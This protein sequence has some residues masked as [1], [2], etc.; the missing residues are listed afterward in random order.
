MSVP[1][2]N[3]NYSVATG[4]NSNDIN[5]IYFSTVDPTAYN[6][7]FPIQKKWYNTVNRSLWMLE[8]FDSTSGFPLANWVNLGTSLENV[9]QYAVLVGGAN[10]TIDS[11][12]P[13]ASTTKVLVS[14]G[15][16]ANPSWQN[17]GSG[18]L[19]LGAFGSSPNSSGASLSGNTLTLQPA[20]A[21]NPGGVS[22]SAQT[23]AGVKTFSSAPILSSLTGVV[24]AN[25]AS[26]IT[27]NTV[28]NHGILIG[29]ASN[30]VSSLG[31]AT[32]GQIPIG[33]T[34]V[35]PVLATITAGSG[36][37]VTNGA[38]S[39]SIA[40]T[41]GN[42]SVN[43]QSFTS[44]GTYTPTTGMKYCKIECIGG[45]GGGGGV[46]GTGSASQ[47]VQAASGGAGGGYAYGFYS[48][49]TIGASQPVV[50]GAGGSGGNSSGTDGSAGGASSVA[51]LM[52]AGGGNGGL[53]V[54]SGN[55]QK[56]L[57]GGQ[58]NGSSGG[59]F[60]AIGSPGGNGFGI[61]NVVSTNVIGGAG[62][63]SYLGGSQTSVYINGAPADTG[64]A[65]AGNQGSA[66]GSGGGG[67]VSY[68]GT[69]GAGGGAAGG[70][71]INGIVIITE[72]IST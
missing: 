12:I 20:D 62:G 68:S 27:A 63:S 72:Y 53:G 39:I 7:N 6:Y 5:I 64:S 23:I 37:S 31:V 14:G 71:G 4:G 49:A 48:A 60:S 65:L 69:G 52:S 51:A 10:H 13:D 50:V 67:A 36:I 32:N 41:L 17:I 28:T 25:G 16:S 54:P 70:N 44:N 21:T 11:I 18:A 3:V 59:A 29:G 15:T 66:A 45:G 24:T 8:S 33:S 46:A 9:D 35:D 22:T 57:A 40:A 43:V 38:G 47:G 2:P 26:A 56:V 34:G 55:A 30:A 42:F 19:A 61:L 58:C 1:T